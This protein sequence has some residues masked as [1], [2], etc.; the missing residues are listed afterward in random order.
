MAVKKATM[1][2]KAVGKPAPRKTAVKKAV[3]KKAA[4]KETYECG[5]CGYKLTA[6]GPN[7][8]PEKHVIL[9]CGK[10]MKRTMKKAPVLKKR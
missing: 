3:T 7:C 10:P 6:S 1:K 9:C 4:G 2:K 5:L 8:C